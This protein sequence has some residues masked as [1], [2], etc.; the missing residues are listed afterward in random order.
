MTGKSINDVDVVI[1]DTETTGLDP[2]SGDRIVEIAAVRLRGKVHLATFCSL[3][4]PGRDVS[5]AAFKVNHIS[6]DMLR[7]APESRRIMP[8]FLDFIKGALLASYN[9][10]FD[11][12]FLDIELKMLGKALPADLYAVDILIM[13]RRL[14][15]GLSGYSLLN[16]A[17]TLGISSGQEHRAYED[18]VLT[19]R[20]FEKLKEILISKRIDDTDSLL[21][22]FSVNTDTSRRMLQQRVAELQ[23]AIDLKLK[24]KLR[25]L[26]RSNSEVTERNVEPL[27][28]KQERGKYY[29]VGNCYLRQDKRTFNVDSILHLEVV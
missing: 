7:G 1:F 4:N 28:I 9:T 29:L 11:L 12:G 21:R 17:R 26:S 8:G 23:E 19:I 3:V 5:E 14:M 10:N 22:L 15:P 18:V 13:A 25:Y 27:E 24:L 16:V 2:F 20:V 6:E